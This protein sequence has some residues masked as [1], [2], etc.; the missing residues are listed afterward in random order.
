M[1]APL[2]PRAAPQRHAF[3]SAAALAPRARTLAR[4]HA[5]RPPPPPR[6]TSEDAPSSASGAAADAAPASASASAQAPLRVTLRTA[7]ARATLRFDDVRSPAQPRAVR[8]LV[9][10]VATDSDAFAAGV[11]PG[12]RLLAVSDPIRASEL[13]TL[14]DKAS[15]RFVRDALRLRVSS[16]VTLLLQP[17]GEGGAARGGVS[18]AE[19]EG[20]G[21]QQADADAVARADAGADAGGVRGAEARASVTVA[22]A[23]EAA[24]ARKADAASN[25][26][27]TTS[28]RRAPTR[29]LTRRRRLRAH[30]RSH[31]HSRIPPASSCHVIKAGASSAARITWRRWG[32]A[33]TAV[34][35]RPSRRR[36]S[37]RRSS[38]SRSRRLTDGS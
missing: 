33:T 11:R 17:G 21:A 27:P 30:I 34:F 18:K 19:E 13:L 26:L 1:L 28:Q 36:C 10:A 6:A 15:L 8:I 12:D 35:S 20:G 37:R 3:T 16:D 2:Q 24:Y 23:L 4:T 9:S 38:F 25:S 29:A 14:N 31:S 7:D 22:Q 5:A 32:A